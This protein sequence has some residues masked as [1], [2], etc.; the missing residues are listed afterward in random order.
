MQRR[1]PKARVLAGR[2]FVDAGSAVTT[3][4]GATGMDGAFHLVERFL[5]A[6]A[7]REAAAHLS[8]PWTSAER[9]R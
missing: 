4:D 3:S 2:K 9:R 6:A 7:A 1:F 5:G 8:Y